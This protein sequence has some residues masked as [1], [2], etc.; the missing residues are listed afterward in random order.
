MRKREE[1]RQKKAKQ[2]INTIP[3]NIKCRRQYKHIEDG[4]HTAFAPKFEGLVWP[5]GE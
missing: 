2:L 3:S 4:E 5:S 1:G